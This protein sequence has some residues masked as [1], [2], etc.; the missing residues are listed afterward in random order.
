MPVPSYHTWKNSFGYSAK[1]EV[2]NNTFKS[3]GILGDRKEAEQG[4]A[5]TALINLGLIDSSV[6]FDVKTATGTVKLNNIVPL[7]TR[8]KRN[9]E[10]CFAKIRP[11]TKLSVSL[12]V[13]CSVQ[14]Y[15]LQ[16][17]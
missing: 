4:A 13:G 17:K 5:Y 12:G 10:L 15:T 8:P 2:A 1:V 16:R 14:C 9:I 6:K 7:M 3:A 11:S